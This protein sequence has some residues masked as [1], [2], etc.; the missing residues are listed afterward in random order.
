[1]IKQIS[2]SPYTN[3]LND[4]YFQ[5]KIY[6]IVYDEF[7]SLLEHE[8]T[9]DNQYIK[10]SDDDMERLHYAKKLIQEEQQFLSLKQLSR[11][12]ALNEFKLKYGFKKLFDSSIGAIVLEQ[13]M[14]EAKRL[15][16]KSELT[17]GE[18]SQ[19]VGYKYPSNFTIVFK[20][21]FGINPR[22]IMKSRKY[23]Y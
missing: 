10:F 13:K 22:D 2:K 12:V 20:K 7:K 11:A 4:L 17:I 3:E 23:Y 19:I 9:I 15:L 18:I 5:S 8:R 21:Y 14:L 1:M 16:E 6:E